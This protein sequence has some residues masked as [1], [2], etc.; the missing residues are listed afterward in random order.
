MQSNTA[1][2]LP[3]TTFRHGSG[4]AFL[5]FVISDV[6]ILG[7]EDI[8]EKLQ[9][10][11]FGTFSLTYGGITVSENDSRMRKIWKLIKYLAAHRDR[12]VPEHEIIEIV[13][14]I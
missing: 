5:S 4:V 13:G 8:L 12:A 11:M 10:T 6:L 1:L 9:V 3:M 7:K 2:P 14:K